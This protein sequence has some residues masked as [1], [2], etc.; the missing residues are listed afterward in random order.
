VAGTEGDCN[1]YFPG[2]ADL[3]FPLACF[4]GVWF[5]FLFLHKTGLYSNLLIPLF[6]SFWMIRSASGDVQLSPF[7]VF[8]FSFVFIF[9]FSCY[10]E[11]CA[12][13]GPFLPRMKLA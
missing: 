1:K 10:L 6:L 11:F 9:Y 8:L 3:P 2:F 12:L 13:F 5:F 4:D 7:L